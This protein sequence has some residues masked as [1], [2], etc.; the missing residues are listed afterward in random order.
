MCLFFIAVVLYVN[1]FVCS[2]LGIIFIFKRVLL[3]FIFALRLLK[4][5]LLYF[6]C[7]PPTLMR[8]EVTET[9]EKIKGKGEVVTVLNYASHLKDI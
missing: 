1:V 8:Q 2:Y 3:K 4:E 5:D 6:A 7:K 9:C